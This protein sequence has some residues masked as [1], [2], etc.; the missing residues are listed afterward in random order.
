MGSL[1]RPVLGP[2]A[3]THLSPPTDEDVCVFKCSVSRETECSRVGKQSFIITLGCNSV[4][5]Q[6][7]TPN[8]TWPFRAGGAWPESRE[9]GLLGC[10]PWPEGALEHGETAAQ[11]SLPG[12]RHRRFPRGDMSMGRVRS[13][14]LEHCPSPSLAESSG[15]FWARLIHLFLLEPYPDHLAAPQ[16]SRRSLCVGGCQAWP[17]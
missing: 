3:H 1:A 17:P 12:S 6:F 4:L 2:V 10:E 8:G 7:A 15:S 16:A 9:P 14:R 13:C 5:I 11:P